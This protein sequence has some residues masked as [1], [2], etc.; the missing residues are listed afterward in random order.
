M[1]PLIERY[2]LNASFLPDPASRPP[3][4]CTGLTTGRRTSPSPSWAPSR[5]WRGGRTR[6]GSPRTTWATPPAG[7]TPGSTW[8]PTTARGRTERTTSTP[9][10]SGRRKTERGGTIGTSWETEKTRPSLPRCRDRR[11]T[12]TKHVIRFIIVP[13]LLSSSEWNLGLWA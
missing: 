8:S 11:D 7:T 4:S 12:K 1:A 9:T 13:S 10:W 6:T 2:F 3:E 5:R